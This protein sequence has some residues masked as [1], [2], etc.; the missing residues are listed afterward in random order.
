M[1]IS[2]NLEISPHRLS[3]LKEF[4]KEQFKQSLNSWN[5]SVHG[6]N[7]KNKSVTLSDTSGEISDEQ[8]KIIVILK[9]C[10]VFL[11]PKIGHCLGRVK[12][13]QSAFIFVSILGKCD[14]VIEAKNVNKEVLEFKN[15]V[16]L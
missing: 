13:V 15:K 8:G 2:Q 11:K 5:H 16:T 4:I 9:C 3:Q 6:L 1:L 14:V 10:S 7:L 12:E